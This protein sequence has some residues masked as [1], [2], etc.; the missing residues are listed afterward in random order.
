VAGGYVKM[1]EQIQ[2]IKGQAFNFSTNWNFSVVELVEKIGQVLG[3][4]VS[5]KV[6][7]NQ[8]NE[9]PEQ[10]LNWGKAKTILGWEPEFTFERGILDS[11][12]WYKNLFNE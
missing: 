2:Q 4:K 9:I 7:N 1:A 12:E 10:S 3:K 11:F 6:L 5:Y 8:T